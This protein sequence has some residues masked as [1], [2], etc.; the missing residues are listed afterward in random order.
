MVILTNNMSYVSDY[1]N[2]EYAVDFY[3]YN[4][5]GIDFENYSGI[6]LFRNTYATDPYFNIYTFGNA[7]LYFPYERCENV[8][9]VIYP[10]ISNHNY[11]DGFEQYINEISSYYEAGI[12]YSMKSYKVNKDGYLEKIYVIPFIPIAIISLIVTAIV[13]I[14]LIKK[15]KMVVKASTANEYLDKNSINYTK[16]KDDF[17]TSHTSSYTVSSSSGGGGSSSRSGSSGGG[18][19]GG[20]GRHG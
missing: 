5:F 1:Q 7:Q 14:I 16:R 17:I 8:L 3:D 6:V 18:H 9:D 20:G 11:Y 19:G 13:M 10:N 15:N 2:E 4:D 12:P